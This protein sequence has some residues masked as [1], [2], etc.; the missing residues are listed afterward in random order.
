MKISMVVFDMAGTTID[1]DNIV[2]KTLQKSIN[3]FGIDVSLDAVLAIGAGKEKL[4]A[5]EDI[6]KVHGN[7]NDLAKAESIF[8]LFLESLATAYEAFDIKSMKHAESVL[9]ELRTRNILVVLNTGYDKNTANFILNKI[10]WRQF[11]HF[12]LLVTATDV[13]NS[14]PAPDMITYAMNLF[15]IH[16]SKKVIKVG[17]SKIDIEEGK[18]A[19]CLYTIGVTTGAQT[20]QQLLEAN[21]DYIMDDLNDLITL[22]NL[23]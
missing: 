7:T 9:L 3:E 11:Y 1:E 19:N 23:N 2:Y 5:I 18:N 14:R 16:D 17:D 4:N 15:S 21:P 10:Q 13:A 22:L 12:D 20:R 6:I 8:K